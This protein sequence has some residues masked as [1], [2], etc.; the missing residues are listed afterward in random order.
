MLSDSV[1]ELF[2]SPLL[3]L[4]K[5]R[6]LDLTNQRG[7]GMSIAALAGGRFPGWTSSTCTRMPLFPGAAISQVVH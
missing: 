7:V 3:E 6:Q 2:A 5:V 4:C 1:L